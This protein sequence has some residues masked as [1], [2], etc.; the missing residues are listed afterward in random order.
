MPLRYKEYGIKEKKQN[1][2]LWESRSTGTWRSHID[3]ISRKIDYT[4]YVAFVQL[5][6]KE[7]FGCPL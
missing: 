6:W 1:L 7:L 4:N 5:N 2:N 3:Y